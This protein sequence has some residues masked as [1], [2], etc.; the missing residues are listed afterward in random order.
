MALKKKKKEDQ[1]LFRSYPFIYSY[2]SL[3]P[4]LDPI[5][6]SHLTPSIYPYI[7][8]YIHTYI[9]IYIHKCSQMNDG[10]DTLP[11]PVAPIIDGSDTS[12]NQ[13]TSNSD[14][15]PPTLSSIDRASKPPSKYPCMERKS[16]ID[17]LAFADTTTHKGQALKAS[18]EGANRTTRRRQPNSKSEPKN[19]PNEANEVNESVTGCGGAG[20]ETHSA[21]LS[22]P[23]EKNGGTKRGLDET[24]DREKSG[25]IGTV[26][27]CPYMHSNKRQRLESNASSSTTISASS[28]HSQNEM[29]PVTAPTSRLLARDALANELKYVLN[30]NVL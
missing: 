3:D 14:S 29:M 30:R 22:V 8:T 13:K 23:T 7:H 24:S 17:N 5:S 26:S 15:T 10:T 20:N 19:T 16:S 12:H 21:G 2:P 1:I 4:S 27:Q 25:D 28:V 11:A 6:R 18:A 9:H